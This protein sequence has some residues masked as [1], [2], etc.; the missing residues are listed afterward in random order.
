MNKQ[1]FW[2]IFGGVLMILLGAVIFVFSLNENTNTCTDNNGIL[3][4]GVDDYICINREVVI[5]HG[6]D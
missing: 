2:W 1:E 6:T 5:R 4:K 3:V